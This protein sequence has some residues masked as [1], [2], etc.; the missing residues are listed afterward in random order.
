M[1]HGLHHA[2]V[3][4]KRDPEA[5]ARLIDDLM[6]SLAFTLAYTARGDDEILGEMLD[7]LEVQL[8]ERV[9]ELAPL[10]RFYD[11]KNR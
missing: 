10:L 6:H 9:A 7:G 8:H 1:M 5:Q 11:G 2:L 4:N 3:R